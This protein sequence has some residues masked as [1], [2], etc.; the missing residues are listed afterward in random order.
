MAMD[1]TTTLHT[2]ASSSDLKRDSAIAKAT[3]NNATAPKLTL[4]PS[5]SVPSIIVHDAIAAST[6]PKQS[7]PSLLRQK[8]KPVDQDS[9]ADL[10]HQPLPTN[11]HSRIRSFHPIDMDIPT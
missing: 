7:P 9:D 11:S 8:S 5:A 6:K 3:T 2:S 10:D 4:A 1:E